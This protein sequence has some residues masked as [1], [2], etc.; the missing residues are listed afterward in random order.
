MIFLVRRGQIILSMDIESIVKSLPI[1]QAIIPALKALQIT[2][3]RDVVLRD[4]ETLIAL[5][6]I[7]KSN[8]NL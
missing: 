5:Q 3:A 6:P 2:D 8:R 1:D 7:L 4:V